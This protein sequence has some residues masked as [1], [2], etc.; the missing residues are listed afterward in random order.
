MSSK[1]PPSESVI[2]LGR[3]I[4][5]LRAGI[6]FA[7]SRSGGPGGQNVNKLNTRAELRVSVGDIVGMN[8]AAL[9][10]LRIGAG[11]RL[12]KNDEIVIHAESSRSQL[13]NKNDCLE[14][15]KEL[16]AL[17]AIAP[18]PRK[19]KKPTRAMIE[20]RLEKKRKQSEKKS[21]RI[22]PSHHD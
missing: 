22:N 18:K 4:H 7:F 8:D 9:D 15:L 21:R 13:D 20:R 5:V 19:K 16:V 14:R 10:R 17:A 3:A 6:R 11:R 1:E 12:T 2:V